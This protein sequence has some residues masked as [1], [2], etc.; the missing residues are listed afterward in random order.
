M[1]LIVGT[2]SWVTVAEADTYKSDKWDSGD[3]TTLNNN[4]KEK[5]LVS[6]YR[7]IQSK[8]EYNISPTSTSQ[9]VKDAQIELADYIIDY[10]SEHKERDALYAQGVRDFTLSKWKEKLE[11]PDLP[12]IVQD[13]LSDSL[14]NAG[15]YM[16]LFERELEA[17]A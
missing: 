10:W 2:N 16:P 7:W 14:L 13:L 9:K 6:A 8:Q 15:G 1:G 17:N 5:A 3:W 11:K 4:E 12:F